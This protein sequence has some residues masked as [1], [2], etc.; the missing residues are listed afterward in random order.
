MTKARNSLLL[1]L[2][3]V[4]LPL[5]ASVRISEVMYDLEGTDTGREWVEVE[6]TGS[7]SIDLSNYRLLEAG[8]NHTLT[9]V[10]GSAVLAP[11]GV[12]V[13]ADDAAKFKAD[14]PAFG[15]ML[16]DSAFSLSNTGETLSIKDGVLVIEDT[17]TYSSDLGG[18]GDGSSLHR[19]GST[20]TPGSPTP[21]SLSSSV[22]PPPPPPASEAVPASDSEIALQQTG[23][24]VE[25]TKITVY[26]GGDSTLVAGASA[27]FEGRAFG[28]SGKP[29]HGAGVRFLWNFGDGS[30]AEG[31]RVMHAYS[32]PGTYVLFLSVSSSDYS[33][34]DRAT[35]EVSEASVSLRSET[36]GGVSVFNRGSHEVDVSLWFIG[37][38]EKTFTLPKGTLIPA[39]A[40]IR[41]AP[42]LLNLPPG[43]A[44]LMFPN[45]TL[46]AR[47]G[48]IDGREAT[49][50]GLIERVALPPQPTVARVY[51]APAVQKIEQATPTPPV[52]EPVV[53]LAQVAAA[54]GAGQEG[55]L[56][57]WLLATLALI[58]V[59]GVAALFIRR[60][61]GNPADA[62]EII[63]ESDLKG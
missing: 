8:V 61:E 13:I 2:L 18:A 3:I 52:P 51:T 48:A 9:L 6:N 58:V 38:G 63:D 36:D 22:V 60:F 43:T 62:Y 4:P 44:L 59:G 54:A 20:F 5:L 34:T 35:I 33:G 12:A 31:E 24:A 21:G 50:Q 40:G 10:E 30:T 16:F 27:Q 57:P 25:P 7:A 41:I 28:L 32:Y 26:A 14:W 11:G 46:A 42:Q 19:S 49:A 23:A 17:A 1:L 55:P 53:P 47:E 37:R 39:Q 29:M 15:G 45:G 56:W